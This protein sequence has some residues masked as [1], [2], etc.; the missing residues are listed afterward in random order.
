[1]KRSLSKKIRRSMIFVTFF[2]VLLVTSFLIYSEVTSTQK[3]FCEERLLTIEKV[4]LSLT[5]L[6]QNGEQIITQLKNNYLFKNVEKYSKDEIQKQLDLI[7]NSN[8]NILHS[9]IAF[10]ND[11]T[12]V[13]NTLNYEEEVTNKDW[14]KLATE[15]DNIHM[16]DLYEDTLT[17]EKILTFFTVLKDLN[18]N[19]IGVIGVDFKTNII[20]DVLT[21]IE[22]S[23]T[24]DLLIIDNNNNVLYSMHNKANIDND[25]LQQI[26]TSVS[27]GNK[28][29]EKIVFNNKNVRISSY[30]EKDFDWKIIAMTERSEIYNKIIK[31]GTIL[32]FMFIIIISIVVLISFKVSNEI[33]KPINDLKEKIEK[34]AQGDLD[35]YVDINTQDEVE[36]LAKSYNKML[37]HLN[38]LI[39]I[40]NI[41][42]ITI[43][44]STNK[45]SK[46]MNDTQI[47]FNSINESVKQISLASEKQT[48]EMQ[49]V[50]VVSNVFAEN[51]N[52]LNEYKQSLLSKQSMMEENN[53]LV[54]GVVDELKD[55]NIKT[56]TS[57]NHIEK[58]IMNLS[59]HAKDIDK[60][61]N[62]IST[63]SQQTNMLALN[64]QIEASRAGELGKGFSVVANEV[65][66]LSIES[67]SQTKFIKE[68][69][70]NIQEVIKNII[71]EMENINKN[72]NNQT[73]SVDKTYYS[74]NELD[75]SIK[76][77]VSNLEGI[78]NKINIMMNES[79]ELSSITQ[80]LAAVSE[81][82]FATIEEIT[83]NISMKT[84]DL[85]VLNQDIS[86][87]DEVAKEL[88]EVISKNKINKH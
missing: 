23:S 20:N 49:R 84:K 34:C 15:N 44:K 9:Y 19:I 70:S 57:I 69:I 31:I 27:E 35:A 4:K 36:V 14:Y 55:K 21:T 25:S 50:S 38:K 1:M 41:N 51:L 7:T 77:M 33:V 82:T 6:K 42:S 79:I 66:T 22:L 39:N 81:E 74:V 52:E 65:K 29:S 10:N 67:S 63:I 58:S 32:I 18:N 85:D 2:S 8:E 43:N 72:I 73:V 26:L 28:I 56:Q 68:F 80:E 12:I 53:K 5:V 46:E 54:I 87:L 11:T 40:I 71:I 47:S 75:N 30:H 78:N 76:S 62:T 61:I 37:K 16:S 86:T 13:S 60:I 3:D 45:I 17:K 59:N 64:A 83:S 88:E 48:E 24:R